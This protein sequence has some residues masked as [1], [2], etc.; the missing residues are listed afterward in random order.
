VGGLIIVESEDGG[1]QNFPTVV[2][3]SAIATILSMWLVGRIQPAPSDTEISTNQA[4]AAA[5]EAWCD[6]T[7]PMV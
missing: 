4:L 2:L 7:Q 1:L 5:A 3:L 6:A